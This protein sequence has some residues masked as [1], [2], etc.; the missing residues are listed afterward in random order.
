MLAAA[1]NAIEFAGGLS[2]EKI[3]TDKM[4]AAALIHCFTVIGEAAAR[5]TESTRERTAQIPWRQVVG[6]RHNLVHVYWGVDFGEI[7]ATIRNDL[8]MFITEIERVLTEDANIKG[9]EN[10]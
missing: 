1:K 4:R 3:A 6:M 8:P 9:Q 10:G 7:V 5:A 2:A